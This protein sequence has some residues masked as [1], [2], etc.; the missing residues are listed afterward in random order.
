M[1]KIS[2]SFKKRKTLITYI[3]AGDPSLKKTEELIFQF[4][5]VGADIIEL[6]I[7][8]SDPL[9]DGPVIQA[10]HARALKNNTKL[11][12]V[13]KLI[14][15]VRKKIQIP[16]V[17]MLAFNLVEQYGYEKFYSDCEKFSVNGVLIP[18]APPEE[19]TN[20]K[21]LLSNNQFLSGV[22]QIFMIAPTTTEKRIKKIADASSGF[23][24]LVSILGI[25]GKRKNLS[26]NISKLVSK[27]KK[28]TDKPIAIGFGISTPA[29]AK[30]A[31]KYT[32]GII[33]GSAIVD[34][35]GQKKDNEAIK[36]VSQL[37]RSLDV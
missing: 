33:V 12:D 36:L 5:K 27:I 14:K 17:F 29:Q 2:E 3:T 25:T 24:Y 34:L 8:F 6:G 26:S 1:S 37:R 28:Y 31:V 18:D 35:I 23:I 4:E 20:F 9:A 7:P 13:F 15:N 21:S 19:L 30:K 11:S 16:I 32:D 22:D 10:S